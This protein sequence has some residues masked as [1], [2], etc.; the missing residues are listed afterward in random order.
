MLHVSVAAAA[1]ELEGADDIAVLWSDAPITSNGLAVPSLV[2]ML[3][4]EGKTVHVFEG[5]SE[6]PAGMVPAAV[7][8]EPDAIVLMGFI[9][10]TKIYEALADG[11]ITPADTRFLEVGGD[12]VGLD[13]PDGFTEGV[14]G[15]TLDIFTG[16]G[17]EDRLGENEA[18]LR[19]ARQQLQ[20]AFIAASGES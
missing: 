2:S 1:G 11:G 9:G 20:Q 18:T 3:E 14:V 19:Q 10:L 4:A 8:T 16:D 12:G 6:N 17:L 15:V 5:T 7:A 13:L